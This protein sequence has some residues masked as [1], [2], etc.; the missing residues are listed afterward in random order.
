MIASIDNIRLEQ[1]PTMLVA[2][3]RTTVPATNGGAV[4]GPLVQEILAYIEVTGV[5]RTGVPYARTSW[6]PGSDIEVGIPIARALSGNKRVFPAELPAGAVAVVWFT[7]P[8]DQLG[9]V[10]NAAREWIAERSFKTDLPWEFYHSDP[11]VV[12]DPAKFETEL[13]FPV[14]SQ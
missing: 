5:E 10:I 6:D 9:P 3:M 13:V 11:R 7:G 2:A 8:Y 12:T 14:Q 4:M 1:R